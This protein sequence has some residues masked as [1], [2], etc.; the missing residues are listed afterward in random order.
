VKK[1]LVLTVFHVQFCANEAWWWIWTYAV[2]MHKVLQQTVLIMCDELGKLYVPT[3]SWLSRNQGGR[4][5]KRDITVSSF[6]FFRQTWFFTFLVSLVFLILAS[7]SPSPKIFCTS[8]VGLRFLRFL[9]TCKLE[10]NVFTI[11]IIGTK[12]TFDFKDSLS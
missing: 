4:A 3:W 10:A 1:P 8:R 2:I 11:Y 6:I 12:I 9:C 5:Y 7:L